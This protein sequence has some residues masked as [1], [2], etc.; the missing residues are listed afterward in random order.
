MTTPRKRTAGHALAFADGKNAAAD[1]VE[2][3][4][5]AIQTRAELARSIRALKPKVHHP[6]PAVK[7]KES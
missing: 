3:P 4:A 7:P 6:I 2:A 5:T 1:L